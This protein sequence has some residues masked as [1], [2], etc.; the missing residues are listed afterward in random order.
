MNLIIPQSTTYLK[1]KGLGSFKEDYSMMTLE[2]PV[3]VSYRIPITNKSHVR[4][5]VGPVLDFGLS[6]KL[7]LSGRTNSETLGC[8][9]IINGM[10]TNERYDNSNYKHHN[11]YE[12]SF[13]LYSDKATM[14]S[15]DSYSGEPIEQATDQLETSPLKRVNLGLRFGAGY[16]YMGISFSIHYQYILT[17]MAN[18]KFW[19]S[20]RWMIMGHGDEYHMTGYSQRN[21]ML[22]LTLG[23]TFRY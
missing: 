11:N 8:Y 16:E 13:D 19:D 10:M 5:N 12:G 18:G 6:S 3:I 20:N 14:N 17:N 9:K 22:M 1:G 2:L 7:N 21:N 4:V 15:T 23:Y